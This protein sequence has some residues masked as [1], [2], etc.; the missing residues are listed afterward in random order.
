[1]GQAA[2]RVNSFEVAELVREFRSGRKIPFSKY[3]ESLDDFRYDES[4]IKTWDDRLE[5]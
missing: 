2:R 1:M 4:S 3:N 5:S